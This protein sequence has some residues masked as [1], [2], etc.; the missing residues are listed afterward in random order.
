[1]T[2]QDNTSKLSEEQI[3]HMAIQEAIDDALR[4]RKQRR[5]RIATA[6]MQGILSGEMSKHVWNASERAGMDPDAFAAEA[7]AGFAD[8]LIAELDKDEE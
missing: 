7:A 3:A 6:A 2:E 4:E 8:A 5:E 1:M